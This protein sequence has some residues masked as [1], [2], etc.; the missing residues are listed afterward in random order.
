MGGRWRGGGEAV[1][2][3]QQLPRSAAVTSWLWQR[4]DV[5]ACAAGDFT[6]RVCERNSSESSAV[7]RLAEGYCIV[8]TTA[9]RTRERQRPLNI[10]KNYELGA[11]GVFFVVN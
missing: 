9:D 7:D 1:L 10:N 8:T 2:G 3:Q 4:E 6:T 11:G 5:A